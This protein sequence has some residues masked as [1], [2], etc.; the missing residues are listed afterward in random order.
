MVTVTLVVNINLSSASSWKYIQ[1]AE[2]S[3]IAISVVIAWIIFLQSFTNILRQDNFT[4]FWVTICIHCAVFPRQAQRVVDVK[5]LVN[6][7]LHWSHC[8]NCSVR[9]SLAFEFLRRVERIHVLKLPVRTLISHITR[10][11]TEIN[12][13]VNG[14]NLYAVRW[15]YLSFKLVCTSPSRAVRC[16]WVVEKFHWPLQTDFR[17]FYLT[18]EKYWRAEN[19]S[20]KLFHFIY[21]II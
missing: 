13:S 8:Q 7:S 3:R 4:F 5:C 15:I 19:Y 10:N 17:C 11:R 1:V 16:I 20:A 18:Q 21:C 9:Y 14:T 12:S 2:Q 6:Y